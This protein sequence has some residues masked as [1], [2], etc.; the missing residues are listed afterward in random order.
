MSNNRLL[1]HPKKGDNELKSSSLSN[2]VQINKQKV[3]MDIMRR[4]VTNKRSFFYYCF[5]FINGN[6][7]E[8][9]ALV[10]KQ[11]LNLTRVK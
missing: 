2:K 3:L 10:L 1:N 9:E 11:A 4:K 5:S 7:E 6:N 8:N